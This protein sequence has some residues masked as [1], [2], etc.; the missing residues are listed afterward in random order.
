M[1]LELMNTIVYLQRAT[2]DLK[3]Q[4]KA[5]WYKVI[6]II[7]SAFPFDS[8]S[9]MIVDNLKRAHNLVIIDTSLFCS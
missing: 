6:F 7:V 8:S 2:A 3:H 1:E 9:A 4:L 5:L